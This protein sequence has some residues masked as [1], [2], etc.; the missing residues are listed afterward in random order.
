MRLNE[1]FAGSS[2]RVHPDPARL[3]GLEHGPVHLRASVAVTASQASSRSAGTNSRST[4]GAGPASASARTPSPT[5]GATTSTSAPAASRTRSC[6]PRSGPPPTT[7]HRRPATR[8]FAGYPTSDGRRR[9]H[10]ACAHDA[11]LLGRG[12]AAGAI[13]RR[14]GSAARWRGRPCAP[15]RLSGTAI[16]AGAKLRIEQTP[17]ATSASATS[18]AAARAWR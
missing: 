6:G 14:R 12:C 1:Q 2:A 11:L 18:W 7:T 16:T 3:A 5:S 15:R 4:S 13:G 10:R 8:K 9:G 17:A